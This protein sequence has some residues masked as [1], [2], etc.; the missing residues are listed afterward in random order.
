MMTHEKTP[1][2]TPPQKGILRV[3]P[4][5]LNVLFDSDTDI[6]SV[7]LF[8]GARSLLWIP[9]N[10][11]PP[12]SFRQAWEILPSC[13]SSLQRKRAQINGRWFAAILIDFRPGLRFKQMLLFTENRAHR[14]TTYRRLQRLIKRSV[15][16]SASRQLDKEM[17]A[18]NKTI[19]S[20]RFQ[21]ALLRQG[22]QG[23]KAE[24]SLSCEERM[25]FCEKVAALRA[26][27]VSVFEI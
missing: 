8:V 1:S 21:N 12:P 4:I 16:D 3:L 11:T 24:A 9:L 13:I 6:Y 20:L 22:L 2:R 19:M 14:E 10:E 5:E 15:R 27:S 25:A 26:V 17:A 18:Q 23:N 7:L